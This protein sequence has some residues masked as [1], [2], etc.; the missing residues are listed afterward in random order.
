MPTWLKAKA[1]FVIETALTLA[2]WLI[3]MYVFYW[4]DSRGI[5]TSETPHRGKLSVALLAA[6]MSASFFV[7]S[8]L[9]ERRRK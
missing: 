5:W 9:S 2:P 6:G 7:H 1:R 8:F 4:L 3:S